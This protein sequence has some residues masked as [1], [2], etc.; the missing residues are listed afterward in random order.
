[1][2]SGVHR[3]EVGAS[4]PAK[5]KNGEQEKTGCQAERSDP[6]RPG[7]QAG[8]DIGRNEKVSHAKFLRGILRFRCCVV[9]RL[10]ALIVNLRSRSSVAEK[11]RSASAPYNRGPARP[12]VPN[13]PAPHT[14]SSPCR[15]A[16]AGAGAWTHAADPEPLL[17]RSLPPHD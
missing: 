4:R 16:G 10:D 3:N 8:A 6:P 14:A 2:R 5:G 9:L 7:V 11:A 15:P 17:R 12:C 13:P 1:M